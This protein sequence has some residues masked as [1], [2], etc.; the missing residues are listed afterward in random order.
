MAEQD[1][2]FALNYTHIYEIQR[3]SDG[4]WLR[5]GAGISN[6]TAEPN[7]SVD[8]TAYYDGEGLASSDVTGGQLVYAFTGH[9]RYGDE[10]QDFVKSL[11]LE[12]G[13][14]RSVRFRVTDPS[15]DVVEGPAVI[16]NISMTGGG[17]ANAKGDVSFEV[18]LCGRPTYTPG[19]AEHMPDT[20]QA[21]AVSVAVGGTASVSP[22]VTPEDASAKC[23][24]AVDDPEK[25]T[26][27]SD[28]TVHGVAQGE[29]SVSVKCA[30]RPSVSCV[31][32]VTVTQ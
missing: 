12:Y 20:V 32:R 3:P 31:V 13:S 1:I 21:E 25:A 18:H 19:E 6:V 14:A 16:A 22:T 24:F 2:G 17:D 10:A 5:I 28:G 11:E 15:G 29:C 8:Q 7:E 26:V 23:V 30:A 4:R 27:D 9:R